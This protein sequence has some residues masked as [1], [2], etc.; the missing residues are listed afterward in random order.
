MDISD[1]DLRRAH[2]A[3]AVIFVS[4]ALASALFSA[5]VRMAHAQ[6]NDPI[7]PAQVEGGTSAGGEEAFNNACRTCHSIKPGDNRLGPSLGGIIGKKAG[8]E[9]GFASSASLKGANITWDAKTLDTFIA[10]P[11]AVIPGNNMK[12]F[13]GIADAA[14][15]AKIVGYLADAK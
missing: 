9:A 10:N 14:V 7:K 6:A 12:P 4:I 15:R 13:T 1:A 2:R 5:T 11:D 8:S 3:A